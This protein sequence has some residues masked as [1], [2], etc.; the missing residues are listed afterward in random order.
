VPA[1]VFERLNSA[2]NQLLQQAEMRVLLAA[3]D[4]LPLGGSSASFASRIRVE[5][6]NNRRL[7]QA[8]H[9]KR[10]D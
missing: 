4:S 10:I 6:E 1:S 7:I 2:V 5:T 9:M 8:T 3:N